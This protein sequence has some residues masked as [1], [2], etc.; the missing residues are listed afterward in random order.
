ME[1]SAIIDLYFARSETAIART[2]EKYGSWLSA[3]TMNIL[4]NRE[5]SEETVEDTYYRTWKSIPPSRPGSLKYF[6]TRIARNLSFDRLDY[7]SA[8]KRCAETVSLPEEL[9]SCLPDPGAGIEE[10]LE[11]R[12]LTEL[13]NRFLDEL[14][15]LECAVFLSRFYWCMPLKKVAEK[16]A[17]TEGKTK[18][19]LQRTKKH[20]RK[21]LE[22]EGIR[23]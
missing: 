6:L 17:L 3:I 22:E 9:E 1:D 4:H 21:K 23:G 18:Y 7:L 15:P 12:E 11:E 10:R 2:A 8:A 14:P 19:L 20:L 5:D 16:Y 13:L